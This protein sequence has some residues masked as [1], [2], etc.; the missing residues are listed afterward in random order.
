MSQSF[1]LQ[2]LEAVHLYDAATKKFGFSEMPVPE[3]LVELMPIIVAVLLANIIWSTI[4]PTSC[5]VGVWG[6]SSLL[7]LHNRTNSLARG[8]WQ[9]AVLKASAAL[10]WSSKIIREK[11]KPDKDDDTNP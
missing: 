11:S 7:S 1:F 9:K 2:A 5:R 10:R 4:I 6:L 8:M 3:F